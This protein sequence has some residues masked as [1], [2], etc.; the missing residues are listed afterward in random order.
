MATVSTGVNM[1]HRFIALLL[2]LYS[3]LLIGTLPSRARGDFDKVIDS[4]M[5]HSPDLPF[6]PSKLV[7]PEETK[8]LWLRALERPDAET[9]CQA[10][11]ALDL[12]HRRG[13][14]G[15]ETTIPTLLAAL[16]REDQH[17]TVRLAVAKTLSTLEA[18]DA[19]VSFLRLAQT[20]EM[21]L[22]EIVELALARW[23]HRPA[24]ELWLKRLRDPDTPRRSLVLAIQS[25]GKVREEQAFDRLREMLLSDRADSG[26]RLESA[27]AL[28]AL[29][30]EGLE[31]D[32]EKLTAD[33]SPR[34]IVLRVAAVALLTRHKSDKA[35]ELLQR[36][37]KDPEPAVAVGAAAR[38]LELD[39]KLLLPLL[40]H[41]QASP[42]PKLRMRAIDCLRRQPS[43]KHVRLL[44]DLLADIH[45]DVRRLAR[46][47]LLEL[48]EKAEFRSQIIELASKVLADR[49]WQGQE[50][51]AIL[52]TQLDHK[53]TT[54]RLLK[55]LT[56]ERP[57][58]FVSA[59]WGLRKLAVPETLP[60]VLKY[61][62]DEHA[63]IMSSKP[64]PGR[65]KVAI[66]VLDHQLSQLN[67]FLGGQKYAQC[68]KEMQKFVPLNGS[69]PLPEARAAAIWTLG[70]LHERERNAEI[71]GQGRLAVLAVQTVVPPLAPDLTQLVALKRLQ[72]EMAVADLARK[73]LGN[74]NHV[75]PPPPPE[76]I[77]V[78]VM[79]AITLGRLGAKD[80][81]ASLR[82]Y[83]AGGGLTADPVSNACGW[84]L[85]RITGEAMPAPKPIEKRYLDWFLVPNP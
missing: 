49:S 64:L 78:R 65:E 28:A 41:L 27:R 19:A 20:G 23:D 67:Q 22:R 62:E 56:S 29:R 15:M 2:S 38:L 83:Y 47:S 80:S 31:P 84:A 21:D 70:L 10:A 3:G 48:S 35:V 66:Q 82:T 5:Y 74:L 6:P 79:C 11:E 39:V 69:K 50:Q 9:R 16:D 52:L 54:T 12:A 7:F 61:V 32:A 4:P 44:G 53:P 33:T 77:R 17:P 13:V 40:D 57:E 30:A 63:R 75:G 68:D 26:V 85:E 71:A 58:V 25:L 46:R 59:A 1:R 55:L 76:D 45:P 81:V 43:E 37:A 14:K 72:D 42:D 36:L 24:R 18:R 51:A 34:G 73:L 60:E 8:A